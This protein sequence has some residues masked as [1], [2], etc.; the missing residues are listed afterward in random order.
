MYHPK[1]Y[2]SAYDNYA[3]RDVVSGADDAAMLAVALT[4]KDMHVKLSTDPVVAEKELALRIFLSIEPTVEVVDDGRCVFC[5]NPT[6]VEAEHV[7]PGPQKIVED[8]KALKEKLAPFFFLH[9]HVLENPAQHGES[10]FM[11]FLD[12]ANDDTPDLNDWETSFIKKLL[13]CD[14]NSVGAWN[15]VLP[16]DRRR[17]KTTDDGTYKVLTDREADEQAGVVASNNVLEVL[18]NVPDDWIDRYFNMDLAVSDQLESF[19][20][21]RGKAL[22]PVDGSEQFETVDETRYYIYQQS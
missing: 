8:A 17:A 18:E 19:N 13:A 9:T 11:S 14:T 6:T 15:G 1:L 12:P 16:P 20:G 2:T 3:I 7:G 10:A 21:G 5:V 4:S 22:N